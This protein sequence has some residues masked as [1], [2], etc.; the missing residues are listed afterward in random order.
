[1]VRDAEGFVLIDQDDE[2]EIEV[3]LAKTA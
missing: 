1:V 2:G 3:R